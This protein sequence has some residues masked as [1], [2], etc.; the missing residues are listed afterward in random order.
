MVK[1]HLE[2]AYADGEAQFYADSDVPSDVESTGV[3]EHHDHH[4]HMLQRMEDHPLHHAL[5]VMEDTVKNAFHSWK[6]TGFP[7]HHFPA[8][9]RAVDLFAPPERQTP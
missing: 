9:K 5:G 3:C 1:D 8:A 4:E 7:F 6:P 2:A